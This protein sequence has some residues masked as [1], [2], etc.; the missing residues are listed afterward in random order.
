MQSVEIGLESERCGCPSKT[1]LRKEF[2]VLFTDLDNTEEYFPMV[3][4]EDPEAFLA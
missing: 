2:R 3:S 1:V 4:R